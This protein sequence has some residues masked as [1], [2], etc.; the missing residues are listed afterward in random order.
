M[1]L[2]VTVNL[3]AT[4]LQRRY[5]VLTALR[6]LPRGLPVSAMILVPLDRG[7]SVAQVGVLTTVVALVAL[8]LDLP[9]SGL[10]DAVGR[11]PVQLMAI[12]LCISWLSVMAVAHS[13]ATFLLA[14]VFF[15]FFQ[16]LDSGP[17]DSWY[18]D[19][20][21]AADPDADIEGGLSRAFTVTGVGLAAGSLAGGGLIAAGDV[22]PISALTV[23]ILV[24]IA[25]QLLLLLAVARLMVEHRP[26]GGTLALADSARSATTAVGSALR[27]AWRSR[28]V[29]A[30]VI[31][32]LLWGFGTVTF[33]TLARVR[34]IDIAGSADRAGAFLGP[35]NTASFFAAAVGAS[36]IPMLFRR[37]GIPWSGFVLRLAQGA[38]VVAAALLGGLVGVLT[39]LVL[40]YVAQGASNPVHTALL[41]QQAEGAFRSSLLSV[42]QMISW[43][44]FAAGSAILTGLADGWSV[45]GAMLLGALALAAAAPLYLSCIAT[46]APEVATAGPASSEPTTAG[47]TSASASL[48]END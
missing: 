16:A 35:M 12:G 37:I 22:G 39:A 26:S 29:R 32:D 19:S 21:Q 2:Q 9:T 6:W 11:R 17:L 15:G 1:L 28:I 13:L 40:C 24:A 48:W 47:P 27:R 14:S 31:A 33:E 10:T 46:P 23:P 43:A 18:V 25:L 3:S 20:A 7:L 5:L 36:T 44:G 34:L 42:N 30:L 8:A 41:H 38:T 45:S 4:Q